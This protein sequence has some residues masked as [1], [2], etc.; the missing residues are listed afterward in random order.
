MEA[1]LINERAVG[2]TRKDGEETSRTLFREWRLRTLKK[3]ARLRRI[4]IPA[5]DLRRF[6][7]TTDNIFSTDLMLSATV[8]RRYGSVIWNFNA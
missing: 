8:R 4:H 5:Y 7:P 3:K 1:S 2:D 6:A